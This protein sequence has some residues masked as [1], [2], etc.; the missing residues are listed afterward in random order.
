MLPPA[1]ALDFEE[2]AAALPGKA[3]EPPAVDLRARLFLLA[4]SSC[5]AA[6]L[7]A[8]S[9]TR[10]LSCSSNC[11]ICSWTCNNRLFQSSYFSSTSGESSYCGEDIAGD[12]DEKPAGFRLAGVGL[13]GV[14]WP[15]GAGAALVGVAFAGVALLGIALVGVALAGVVAFAGVALAGTALAAG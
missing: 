13:A 5:L 8:A 15:V 11:L 12:A 1:F 2:E 10:L 6:L 14:G 3:P 7:I 9:S 4:F